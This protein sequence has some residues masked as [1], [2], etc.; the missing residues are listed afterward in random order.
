MTEIFFHS[1]NHYYLSSSSSSINGILNTHSSYPVAAE[2]EQ[3]QLSLLALFI[4]LFRKSCK[5]VETVQ[6]LSKIPS[7]MEIGLPTNV[8]HVAHVTFDRF[9]GFLGLPSEFVPEIPSRPPSASASVFGVSTDSMQLSFDSRGNIVPTILLMMQRRLYLQGGLQ[10]EGIFRINP[11]NGEEE[12]VREELN[13]GIIPDD[14]DIHC[15]A[16][17][18]KAWFRELPEGLLDSISPEEI[19]EARSEDDCLNLV[20]RLP[21]MEGS[22]LNWTVNLMADVAEM[23]HLNK[24]NPRNI[25]TVF[26]PNMT[27][28]DDPM[29]ALVYV[30]Q[31]M[32][33]LKILITKNLKDREKLELE[34]I[35]VVY[36]TE[37]P[38]SDEQSPLKPA[39]GCDEDEG[40]HENSPIKKIGVDEIGS[41]CSS[42]KM[43]INQRRKTNNNKGIQSS[44]MNQK[45]GCCNN[46]NRDDRKREMNLVDRLS[47]SRTDLRVLEA[48]R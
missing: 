30:V 38:S 22:L 17:L 21:A 37:P 28:M 15:L 12:D 46:K 26:A 9:N 16:G 47:S 34:S 3:Q 41:L 42:S 31:V 33:F 32:N 14:V 10:T 39:A 23:E 25:A 8:R 40:I 44:N 27:Q 7:S 1:P 5:T 29:T 36:D 11:E 24:M 4:T 18:I 2:S 6:H 43:M 45:K 19:M 20:K 35:V 48:W 13:R